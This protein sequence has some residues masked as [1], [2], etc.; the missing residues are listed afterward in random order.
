MPAGRSDLKP[1]DFARGS[2][3]QTVR[4]RFRIDRGHPT[5]SNPR[6]SLLNEVSQ[7]WTV[8]RFLTLLL[9]LASPLLPTFR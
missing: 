6:S 5:L 7:Y 2:A 4:L 3:E 1:T 8:L 9:P